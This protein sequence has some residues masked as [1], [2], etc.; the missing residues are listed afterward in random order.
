MGH[1][2]ADD[3][4]RNLLSKWGKKC[5]FSWYRAKSFRMNSSISALEGLSRVTPNS[6]LGKSAWELEMS[7]PAFPLWEK[8]SSDPGTPL[9]DS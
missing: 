1:F 3:E 7:E 9:L 5:Y 2:Y 8:Q 4:E 6:V